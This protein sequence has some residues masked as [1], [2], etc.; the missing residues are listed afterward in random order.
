[1]KPSLRWALII[2][3]AVV[4]VAALRFTLFRPKPIDVDV[5]SAAAGSVEDAVTNSRAGTVRSRRRARLGVE[6]PGKVASI[7][8]REGSHVT[9]GTVLL[10]LDTTTSQM[11]LELAERDLDAMCADHWRWQEANPQGYA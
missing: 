8:H 4:A 10:S 9:K 11:E 5:Y 7:P 3:A 6:L 2:G 1:M